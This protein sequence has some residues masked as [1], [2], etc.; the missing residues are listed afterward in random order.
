MKNWIITLTLLTLAGLFTGCGSEGTSN[1]AG[2]ADAK[3]LAD[4][5]AALAE[6]DAMTE[7]YEGGK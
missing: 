3:A 1:V 2:D 5:E 6:A 4:Y 7:G